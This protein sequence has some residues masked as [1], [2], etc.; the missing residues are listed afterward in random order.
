[1]ETLFNGLL[2]LS[3]CAIP[4]IVAA[5]AIRFALRRMPKVYSFAL[6]LAVFASLVVPLRFGVEFLTPV[7]RTAQQITA[8]VTEELTKSETTSHVAVTVPHNMQ[9]I[10]SEKNSVQT[11]PQL[12]QNSI[13]FAPELWHVWLCGIMVL[14]AFEIVNFKGIYDKTRFA[15]KKQD[16]VWLCDEVKMPFVY[17]IFKPKIILPSDISPASEKYV[18]QHEQNHLRRKDYITKPLCFGIVI[19][20]WFNPFVW[21][22]FCLMIKDMELSCD[23]Q[24][25]KN[26]DTQDVKEYCTSLLSFA[27]KDKPYRIGAVLFGEGNCSMRIKNI[28]NFKQPKKITAVV[29]S[30]CILLAGCTAFATG[31]A[32]TNSTAE[33][34]KPAG[35]SAVTSE[36]TDESSSK[37][38]TSESSRDP[39]FV[40]DHDPETEDGLDDGLYHKVEDEDAD[41]SDDV[42]GYPESEYFKGDDS[43]ETDSMTH[44]GQFADP[45]DDEEFKEFLKDIDSSG[46]Y[47]NGDTGDV[48]VIHLPSITAGSFA[49][50]FDT[51]DEAIMITRGYTGNY[52]QHNGIDWSAPHGTEILAAG[53]GTVVWA[54]EGTAGYGY[55]V[56]IEHYSEFHT[57]YA[58]CSELLVKTGDE[59][60]KGD[61]IAKVGCTG[62]STG[63]HLHFEAM[64]GEW[65]ADKEAN[66]E[67][68]AYRFN[69]A[70]IVG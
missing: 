36:S 70:D 38:A 54:E 14:A 10:L 65:D 7:N 67:Q 27:V 3:L 13:G 26:F 56:V 37:D 32:E 1:M 62:N 43:E 41:N 17:G 35:N 2:K 34:T 23:E 68:S 58:H 11:V 21:L 53:D 39:E 59:V 55:Y 50:P 28:L 15:F 8:A 40:F 19:L 61:V 33:G 51:S 42:C 48:A 24:V 22:A 18:I 25:I 44:T 31:E 45:E 49:K 5:V 63:N 66:G 69:P 6:W 4:V 46:V 30:L 60:K 64:Y 16:N 52:P 57:L 47:I 20:H 12:T 9:T 29:L